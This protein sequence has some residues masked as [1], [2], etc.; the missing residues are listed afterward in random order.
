M[1]SAQP[2]IEALNLRI[3]GDMQLLIPVPDG[4]RGILL[5]NS[6]LQTGRQHAHRCCSAVH[7]RVV[8]ASGARRMQQY[9][10]WI[11][12]RALQ[13]LQPSS[14]GEYEATEGPG[15]GEWRS[16]CSPTCSRYDSCSTTKSTGV[17]AI[18]T[19]LALNIERSTVAN[20]LNSCD[21]EMKYLKPEQCF[22]CVLR[23]SVHMLVFC[24]KC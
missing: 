12:S 8:W 13:D 14:T 23:L 21:S 3:V 19:V 22:H 9:L 18:V 15:C 11:D 10:P 7:P 24:A 2:Q 16:K 5:E 20:R 6:V 4:G 1:P 17:L